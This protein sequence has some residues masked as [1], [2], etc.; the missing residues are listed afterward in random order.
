MN[1]SVPPPGPAPLT[2]RQRKRLRGLAHGLEPLVQVGKGLVTDAVVR[3]LDGALA[4]HEL[5]KV[6]FL[7]GK[8]ER[9][10]LAEELA[11]R[12]RADLAG[13]VGHVAT[14]FRPARDEKRR[15]IRPE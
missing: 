15:R 5:V 7:E 10:E 2:P 3:Q 11:R 8:A 1:D 6:R 14:Y 9:R 12:T 4:A 13:L